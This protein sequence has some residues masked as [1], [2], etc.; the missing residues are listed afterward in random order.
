[1]TTI[2]GP[3]QKFVR[4][5]TVFAPD[6]N[7]DEAEGTINPAA[8]RLRDGTLALYPRVVARGNV[9]R[10]RRCHTVWNGDDVRFERAGFAL[11]PQADYELR[12]KPGGYGCEDPRV[13]Y[14]AA[15]DTYL[16]AY[17][18][19][20]PGGAQ[21]AVAYSTD[22]WDWTR[23]GPVAFRSSP[24]IYGDKDAAF[25]P[26]VVQ[27]P[28]GET[29]IALL[30]RPTLH[31]TVAGGRDLV[32]AILAMEPRE[33]ESI[34]IAYVPLAAVKADLR[35]LLDVRETQ[36]IMHP[37]TAWGAI[38]VGAGAPPVRIREGWLLV[39]HGIDVLSGHEKRERPALVYRAGIAILDADRPDR[40]LFRAPQPFLSP[41]LPQEREGVVDDVVFPTALDPRPEFGEREYD[42]YYGMGDALIGRGRLS[43]AGTAS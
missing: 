22:G 9:S 39:Y 5:G 14:V 29:S 4:L 16:M 28:S 15:L 10:V 20:G 21:V 6:G 18:A 34:C 25:F 23:L 41:E 3:A 7:E 38:K 42:V 13:T 37:D 40:V 32:P 12:T 27:S 19:Y 2:S 24:Q 26:D 35:A 36:Q 43:L 30:H 11:E 33:R 17:C 8:A 1:M 31:V